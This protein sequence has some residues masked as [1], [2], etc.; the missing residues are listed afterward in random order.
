MTPAAS[1]PVAPP[2]APIHT[3]QRRRLF[4]LLTAAALLLAL[5]LRIGVSIR[6]TGMD[7]P[8]E[9]FQTI[10]PAHHL[11]YGNWVKTWEFQRGARSWV[12]PAALSLV[13]R[14]TAWL[15]AGSAGYL[16]GIRIVLSLLSL[17]PLCF[18]VRWAWRQR[19]WPAALIAL[20]LSATWYQLVYYAPKALSE[21][22]AGDFLLPGLYFGFFAGGKNEAQRTRLLVAGLFCGLALALRMQLAPVVLL[23]FLWFARVDWKR[24]SLWLLLG[25][26]LPLLL[27]G[28]VD[29]LTWSYPFQSYIE[30]FRANAGM[31]RHN[32]F[33]TEPVYWYFRELLKSLSVLTIFV[34]AGI[35]EAP[36]LGW[37]V[38]ALLLPHSFVPHKELRFLTPILPALVLLASLGL[39]RVSAMASSGRGRPPRLYL[40]VTVSCLFCFLLS[41]ALGKNFPRWQAD[42]GSLSAF[43]TLSQD[44]TACGVAIVPKHWEPYGGYSY[45]HRKI[46][47]YVF[48]NWRDAWSAR[49]SFNTLAS[50]EALPT[51]F[52]DF[53]LL[54]CS[55]GVCL[56]RRP[57]DCQP[58]TTFEINHVLGGHR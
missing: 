50:Y 11:V 18:V 5:A 51:A 8:D 23:A 57:G 46:P 52:T 7:W 6:Y 1:L 24:R 15:G 30:N 9:I 14:A 54:R 16:L 28:M 17:L 55:G 29:A 43:Q 32:P 26:A 37:I 48:S 27:F 41:A 39:A 58:T 20:A 53:S 56:Y 21:M 12:F 33:G 44:S 38:L 49:A 35:W 2:P 40:L 45:L 10:E 19:G 3:P 31:F 13:M 36:F 4:V 47:I 22:V 42:S 25:A 34:L